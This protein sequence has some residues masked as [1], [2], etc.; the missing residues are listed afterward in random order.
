MSADN[1]YVVRK[2]PLGGYAAVEYSMSTYL[3]TGRY[4]APSEQHIGFATVDD[5][6]KAAEEEWSEYGVTVHKEVSSDWCD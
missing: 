2:H 1:G 5:A 4:P 3:D 6:V